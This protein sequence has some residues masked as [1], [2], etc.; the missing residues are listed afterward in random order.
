VQEPLV[1]VN[2]ETASHLGI[3]DR[4]LVKVESR[5]GSIK[6]KVKLT[7]DIHPM[8]VAIQHGWSEANCNYLTDEEKRDPVSAYPGLRSVLCRLV[9]VEGME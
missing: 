7:Q 4:D 2:P 8:V 3:A 9:K 5:M 6:L 1:E